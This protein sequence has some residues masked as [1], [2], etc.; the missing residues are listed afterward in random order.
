MEGE[1]AYTGAMRLGGPVFG[2]HEDPEAWARAVKALGYRAAYC[3][4]GLD[5]D[6]VSIRAFSDAAAREGIV[7]AEVGAWCS[8]LGPDPAAAADA[9][10]RCQRCL[11]LAD[12]IGALCAVNVAGS[13]GAI[14]SGPD[15][16]DLTEET[17]G[18]VVST[19]R[20]IIDAVNPV[21]A[22]YT[23]EAM[24]WMVPDSAESYLRL[25]RAV[26][27]KAFAVH[28]DPV[29]LVSSPQL[30]YA[31]GELIAE[32]FAKLGPHVKSCHAKDIILREGL[33]VHLDEV[34]PGLGNL[35]YGAFL[36]GLNGLPRDVPLMLEHLK[37]E[38]E[39]LLAAEHVRA[40]AARE[41]LQL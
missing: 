11:A 40:V 17:F 27:R 5:A 22:F 16:A 30:Y 34:R 32:C 23:L 24:P 21:R 39:Y 14:W 18:M 3:P 36:R 37:G 31:N 15:G 8:P 33:T 13:R 1:S 7:I 4:V 19:V 10:R 26:D 41:G 35:D 28:L 38:S 9:L 2:K 29:N 6:S 25:I 20:E 12:E